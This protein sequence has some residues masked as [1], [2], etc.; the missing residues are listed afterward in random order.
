MIRRVSLFILV[1]IILI[2]I[3]SSCN[4]TPEDEPEPIVIKPNDFMVADWGMSQ[5]K[6]QKA[7]LP[8][9]EMYADDTIM[10][11]EINKEYDLFI[12][13]YFFEDDALVKG[14]CR[15]E[16]GTEVWSKRVPLMIDS[17]TQFR[18]EIIDIY[19]DP[20]DIDYR[21]WIDKD[22]EYEED[23]DMHNLYYQRLEYLT[24][25]ETETSYM[26]L[27]LLYIDRNFKFLYEAFMKDIVL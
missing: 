6:V 10:L 18:Q 12:V 25:W 23:D 19:G 3:C 15:V 14:E 1:I 21:I 16:M 11:Y 22:P 24:E 26:S 27:R 5:A 8:Q 7:Q 13:S 17:Y 4:S 20:K 9:K 2:S